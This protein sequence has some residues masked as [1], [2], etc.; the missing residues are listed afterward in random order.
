MSSIHRLIRVVSVVS[1]L[2][3]SSGCAVDT[4][5]GWQGSPS[6]ATNQV[7]DPFGTAD[8]AGKYVLRNNRLGAEGGWQ[9]VK[10]TE[11][12]FSIAEF[13]GGDPSVPVGY[14]SMSYGCS[15]GFCTPESVLP[16]K[17]DE[18]SSAMA[19]VSFTYV[20]D[21]SYDAA[22][23]I[24]LD[25]ERAATGDPKVEIMIYLNSHGLP[26]PQ[27]GE[28]RPD[29]VVD[30]RTWHVRQPQQTGD[31]SR[32]I[33]YIAPEP[34]QDLAINLLDFVNDG[35]E[36]SSINPSWYLNSIDAGF[37]CRSGCLGLGVDTFSTSVEQI[38]PQ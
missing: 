14:P 8:I 12:G 6:L 27:P 3:I 24:A 32:V 15:Y 4:D 22:A 23:V 19:E 20:P 10:P 33:I 28:T 11:T 37:Q 29:A 9:C 36:R 1:V 38:R 26:D 17:L 34:I 35:S 31:G 13:V 7:C 30:R 5:S 25:P 2:L 21:G 18:I 16:M